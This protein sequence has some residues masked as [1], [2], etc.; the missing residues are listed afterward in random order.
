V[1]HAL[2]LPPFGELAD[3]RLLLD[4]AVEAEDAGWDGI[5]LWDHILR[6]A[7]DPADIADVWVALSAMATATS[8][9]R[10]GP[11]VTPV[12]RRRP[13][14]L[15]REVVTLDHLSRGRVVLGLGLGVDTSGE[16]SRFGEVVDPTRRGDILDEGLEVLDGLWSGR[17]V[18]HRGT[19]FVAT[20]VTFSPVAVQRPRVPVWLAARGTARRPVRRAARWDGLFPIEVDADGLARMVDLVV[21]ERGGLDGFD[22]AVQARPGDD[23]SGLEK[24]GA[25]W[26]MWTFTPGVGAAEVRGFIL[27]RA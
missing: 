2:H 20:G 5:F 19:Q 16:L 25:T 14:K 6:P 11:M 21:A 15:A 8:T 17:P 3:P 12:V 24:R 27:A 10:L 1:R 18:E 26:A 4:L 7:T 23:V 22:V 9:I 13:Q